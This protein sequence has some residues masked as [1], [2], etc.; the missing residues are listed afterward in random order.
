MICKALPVCTQTQMFLRRFFHMRLFLLC[1]KQGSEK[2]PEQPCDVSETDTVSQK[3]C[4]YPDLHSTRISTSLLT[5]CP[6]SI[7]QTLVS[8]GSVHSVL[9]SLCHSYPGGSE[10]SIRVI[11]SAQQALCAHTH[12]PPSH[13]HQ[14]HFWRHIPS[15]SS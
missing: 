2:F 1:S 4:E 14:Q 10:L 11:P 12:P 9:L 6:N 5:Q 13:S 7:I 15:H 8:P 3:F